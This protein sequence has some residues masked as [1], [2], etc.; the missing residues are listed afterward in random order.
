MLNT[1]VQ[2]QL[3]QAFA[4]DSY[5]WFKELRHGHMEK[6]QYGEPQF[7]GDPVRGAKLWDIWEQVA[8]QNP[9]NMLSRQGKII[10]EHIGEMIALTKPRN[11]LLDL[12]PG[13]IAAVQRNTVPFIEG[14]GEDL[15]R[16][17]AI[18]IAN[19]A[20]DD[21]RD[22]IETNSDLDAKALN[23]DFLKLGLQIPYDRQCVALFMGGTIGN[24]EA[25]PN[26]P[27]AIDLM[28]AQITKLKKVLPPGTV[29]F[30]GLE[31]PKDAELLYADY[32]PPEHREFEINIM[33]GIKRDVLPDE[34]GFNPN[35]WKYSMQ[36]YPEAHQFCHFAEATKEQKFSMF[37][38]RMEIPQGK[39]L[40]IDNSFKFPVLSMQRASQIA[41]VEYLQPFV[42]KDKRMAIHALQL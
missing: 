32:D 23:D 7:T 15:S 3:R 21:A 19:E 18:D 30:I 11:T 26:T 22:F 8:N 34:D 33:H 31:L 28:A 42:D 1:P 13:G 39:R 27:D 2:L 4:S 25:E 9:Q 5:A 6:W 36:W 29:V 40:L 37:G 24:F 20:A 41:G 35:A 12:G 38:E 17:I 10:K 14:Y 16:Y